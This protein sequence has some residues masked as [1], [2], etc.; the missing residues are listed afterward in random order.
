MC[1]GFFSASP[2]A[3]PP[4]APPILSFNTMPGYAATTSINGGLIVD[5]GALQ[6]DSSS[7][8]TSI[9]S[10]AAGPS[11]FDT[12]AGIVSW[13]DMPT[14]T[15]T[16]GIINSYSAQMGGNPVLTIFGLTTAAGTMASGNVGIGTTTPLA[17]LD[18]A[19]T[20]GSQADL[21]NVSSTTATDVVSSLFRI[22]A[23]GNVGIGTST[24][25]GLLSVNPNGI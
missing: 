9:S 13:I 1:R 4:P 17:I 7:G 3:P 19:G 16:A 20:L 25:W 21:F 15:T 18:V 14:A 5:G 11:C 2:F 22:R 24:P 23:N 6:Y 8:I 10:L 12:D